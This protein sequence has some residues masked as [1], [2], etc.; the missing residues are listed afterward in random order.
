P[1][2]P[3][4]A[5]LAPCTNATNHNFKNRANMLTAVSRAGMTWRVYSE[6]QNPGRDWRLSSA[7]D[8]TITAPDHVYTSDTPVG[9]AG[10]SS[11]LLTLPAQTYATKHNESVNFQDVRSAF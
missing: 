4:P 5:G 7:A 3:L 9:P 10:N 11:L 8:A 1:D 6:T 2:D